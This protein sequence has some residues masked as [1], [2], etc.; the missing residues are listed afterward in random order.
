MQSPETW[1]IKRE[2]ET[3]AWRRG[4]R[5]AAGLACGLS[6]VGVLLLPPGQAGRLVI[7]AH[8]QPAIPTMPFVAIVQLIVALCFPPLTPTKCFWD[9]LLACNAG[10]YREFHQISQRYTSAVPG[11]RWRW[12]RGSAGGGCSGRPRAASPTQG[13]TQPSQGFHLSS[14]ISPALSKQHPQKVFMAQ[15]GM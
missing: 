4:E 8:S 12:P 3:R 14:S 13:R 10:Y 9:L 11:P 6:A 15:V 7:T 2:R 1:E 5:F